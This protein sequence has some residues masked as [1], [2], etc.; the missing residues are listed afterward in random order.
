MLRQVWVHHVLLDNS[1]KQMV[2]ASAQGH[3]EGWHTRHASSEET[4]VQLA[5]DDLTVILT[6]ESW[7]RLGVTFC[8][9]WATGIV[10]CAPRI[11]CAFE[12]CGQSTSHL[13]C[14]RG[15]FPMVTLLMEITLSWAQAKMLAASAGDADEDRHD[16]LPPNLSDRTS[17]FQLN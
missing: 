8:D 4:N 17:Y 1:E 9:Q 16:M 2:D 13:V 12:K 10:P 11:V 14:P 15:F 6:M 7:C 3:A 5:R